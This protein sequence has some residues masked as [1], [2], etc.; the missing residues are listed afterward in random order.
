MGDSSDNIPGCPG[1]GEKTAIRLLS[2]FGSIDGLL[3]N[4]EKLKGSL[5]EKIENNREQ[6]IFS[7]LL[8]TIRTDVPIDL[9]L[10]SLKR[11]EPDDSKLYNLFEE[12]EFRSLLSR[13]RY[14]PDYAAI[15]G[16]TTQET[17]KD[18]F[19][20]DFFEIFQPEIQEGFKNSIL[21]DLKSVQ[22]NYYLIDNEE[23]AKALATQINDKDS[24]CFDTETSIT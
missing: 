20:G 2:E 12:L 24:I 9:D 23:K 5:K 10:E 16:E 18:G 22:H 15:A 7:R 4:T 11:V 1:V 6:I 14:K 3:A 13:F 8:A 17:K 21:K 19:H